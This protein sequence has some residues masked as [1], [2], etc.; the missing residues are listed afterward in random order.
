MYLTGCS[1][2]A[3]IFECKIVGTK[4]TPNMLT[5]A[6][7]VGVEHGTVRTSTISLSYIIF[8]PAKASFSS[9][10]GMLDQDNFKGIF[11]TNVR[12]IIY[13]TDYFLYGFSMLT[14]DSTNGQHLHTSIDLDEVMTIQAEKSVTFRMIYI[15]IG[16]SAKESCK[17]SVHP[18]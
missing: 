9:Y 5:V 18:Y 16:K 17:G 10:G 14:F 4:F 2:G 11:N 7:S 15:A 8:S 1:A 12:K 13:K 3:G 6:A